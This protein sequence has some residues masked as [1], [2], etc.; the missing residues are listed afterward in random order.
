[1]TNAVN[2]K[3]KQVFSL[4]NDCDNLIR[5]CK[6]RTLQQIDLHI[7][8]YKY[9]NIDEMI[10]N[11]VY[12][13]V[14]NDL[15]PLRQ[16]FISILSKKDT[17]DVTSL[18]YL[19]HYNKFSESVLEC[20]SDIL[21]QIYETNERIPRHYDVEYKRNKSEKYKNNIN[22]TIHYLKTIPQP[23][24][25]TEEWHAFRH[26]CI[27]ASSA[28]KILDSQKQR[29]S[30]IKSKLVDTSK[31]QRGFGTN[32]ESPFHH[33]HKYEPLSS[34]LYEY[35]ND[36]KI[37]EFGCIKHKEY[38]FIGASPD[39]INTDPSSVK[40][41]TMLEIKNVVSR[42]ITHIPKKEYW[43]QMQIQMEV[44]D[45]DY[46]DFLETKFLEYVDE[47]EFLNDS[48]DDL[49]NTG[50]TNN[51]KPNILKNKNNKYI[52]LIIMFYENEKPVYE[53]CP[54]WLNTPSKILEW[55]DDTINKYLTERQNSSWVN[56]IFWK[57]EKYSCVCVQRNREWFKSVLPELKRGWDIIV[58]LR[59]EP[60]SSLNSVILKDET[61][62][63]ETKSNETKSNKRAKRIKKSSSPD[64]FSGNMGVCLIKLDN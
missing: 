35:I 7:D 1:M 5:L 56:N 19:S 30:Y 44:C 18:D 48:N 15:T 61:K 57:C 63:N 6:D 60:T 20:I 45:L 39:G 49:L 13:E 12:G 29:D 17:A 43:I 53:Y 2:K 51:N 54:L 55:K 4:L 8:E 22:D 9:E 58:S 32:I 46:C 23:E 64:I 26:N 33:G 16:E 25:K 59:Q 27:T 3:Y 38:D 42:N 50:D 11:F 10:I 14:L 21:K 34:M 24:Q 36:T 28:W 47:E 37:S 31:D 40:Y 41:G 52:G 62:S